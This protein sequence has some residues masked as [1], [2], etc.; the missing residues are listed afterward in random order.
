ME[1]CPDLYRTH[2]RNGL[3]FPHEHPDYARSWQH[4]DVLRIMTRRYVRTVIGDMCA[5]GLTIA[6][7]D[8][9]A[10]VRE[11]LGP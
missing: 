7:D 3:Y 5:F 2:M 8:E 1:C 6:E 4:K 11:L 9:M 10:L